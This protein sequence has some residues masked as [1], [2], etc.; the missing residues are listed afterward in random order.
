MTPIL[1]RR[2][3]LAFTAS[4]LAA[5]LAPLGLIDPAWA[6]R[7]T[8]T[9][10]QTE[11]PFYPVAIPADV[12]NDLVAVAG[13]ATQARGIVTLVGGRVLD[14][15]GRPVA[16]ATVEIWQCD[17]NGHYLHPG[18]PGP[19]DQSFQGFGRARTDGDGA[20]RFRTIRPVPYAGRT[21]HIH[22]AILAPGRP[23]LVTQMFVAGEKGNERDFLYRSLD[24]ESRKSVTVDLAEAK[25]EAP[26]TLAG[27]FDIVLPA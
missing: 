2:K 6:A 8:P 14:T 15:G 11:G 17:A 9:P 26:G 3:I 10:R 20:Y 21:P 16:G 27:S 5:G 22:F 24:A 12:D 18:D 25:G 1:K 19:R 4:G 23:R 13:Q 7:L